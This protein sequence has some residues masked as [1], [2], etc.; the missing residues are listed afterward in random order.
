ME[1]REYEATALTILSVDLDDF[2]SGMYTDT[3]VKRMDEIVDCE[4]PITEELLMKRLV[5]S[6]GFQKIG[7]RLSEYLDSIKDRIS[8]PKERVR[9]QVIYHTGRNEDFYR[10]SDDGIERYRFSYQIPITEAAN[11]MLA[12]FEDDPAIEA[13]GLLKKELFRLFLEKLGYSKRGSQ[14]DRLFED[15]FAFLKENGGIIKKSNGK[16]KKS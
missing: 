10:I 2:L 16:F 13:K 5:N 14:I 4:G 9:S 7:S 1:K 15:T 3:A 6:F 12:V 11:A 8:Y